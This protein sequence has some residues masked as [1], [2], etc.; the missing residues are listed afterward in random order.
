[1]GR[2]QNQPDGVIDFGE[3]SDVY[4]VVVAGSGAAGLVA[5][6]SAAIAGAQVL[7]VESASLFGGASAVSG[8]QVW[9]PGHH[10]RTAGPDTDRERLRS[11]CLDNSHERSVA[12]VEAFL[13]AAPAMAR[14]VEQHTP[15]RFTVMNGPD[16]L[17]PP[18]QTEGWNLEPAP[19]GTGPFDEWQEWVWSPPYPAVLTNDE[20]AESRM[21]FGA[22]PPV[23]LFEQRMSAGEVTLGV[24]LVI[25]LLRGCLDAGVE[26]LGSTRLSCLATEDAR[27]SGVLLT[28]AEGGEKE[29]RLRRGVV[30]STGGF[31]HDPGL[32]NRLLAIPTTV[33]AS[34]PVTTGDGLRLAA[35][36]GAGLAHLSEAWYWP[37]VPTQATWGETSTPRAEIMLAER[38]LPHAIWVNAAGQRF[39]NEA[40]HN[41]AWAFAD[42]DTA[43]GGPANLPAFVIGD[44]QYRAR[45]PLA[46]AGP[47]QPW[48][49]GVTVAD[50]L[51]G[52]S[53]EL[54]IDPEGLTATVEEFNHDAGAGRDRQYRR[55]ET[56]YERTL[57]DPDAPHPNLGT[58]TE[59]PFFALP[60][61]VGAV[62]TKG[63]AVID[64][65]ARVLDWTGR[66]ISGLFA[67]GNAAAAPIGPAIL[68]S[69]MTLGLAMTFGWLAGTTT[70]A[71]DASEH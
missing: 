26:L 1:M 68:S 44:A 17:T 46:G 8:G 34:P 4:D 33:P 9:V 71:G 14:F 69:G 53:E 36:A 67:A 41:C 63:G 13:D 45:Y 37:V 48:P 29:V 47:E 6:L 10:L 7:V 39:V 55:G 42:L 25:G 35:Q 54:G 43:S 11:Y 50:T 59:P 23:E 27:V 22:A 31:E 18:E 64:D 61:S 49:E 24:G 65:H 58:I 28:N 2:A 70:A 21:I 60:L 19:L 3:V 30:L 32:V 38:V 57:G 15:I 5:A 52:L 56:A 20:V 66:P 62:G 16:S 12:M 51:A 40:S